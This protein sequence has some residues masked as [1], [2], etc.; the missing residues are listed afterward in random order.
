VLPAWALGGFTR[1][2]AGNPIIAPKPESMFYCP[3]N[4]KNISWESNDTFNPA[5]VIKGKKIVVMYRAEDKSGEGIGFRTS[6]IGYARSVDGIQM[7]RK[8]KPVM[9]P[10]NDDQKE[11]DWP[12]GCE[13]PRVAVTENGMYVMFYTAWN[14]KVARLSVATSKNLKKWTKHGPAFEEAHG[15]KFKDMF[16]KSASI[17]TK[18]QGEKLVITKIKDQYWIYWGE[19]HVYA[20]T[21]SNLTDW[22]P[23]LDN[24]GELKILMSPRKGFFDSSLTEC[25][26]PA[27]VTSA[28][29]VMLYNGKNAGD[30]NRDSTFTA[31]SYCAG[32]ALFDANEPTKFINR[33]DKPFLRPL[34]PYEKS[35]QYVNGTVFIEGLVYF[36]QKWFLYYGCAD[37]RVSV[38]I[39]DP[40]LKTNGDSLP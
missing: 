32:Q 10:G 15:G 11:T 16:T 25:G 35:G 9:Y 37:S 34:L 26:P 29:I 22:M 3:M 30:Q 38:A 36:K 13:D 6:R 40:K 28:G 12:G 1:I 4:K 14:R 2:T 33:L 17:I 23:L 27:V 7:K 39:Y 24:D 21:S 19:Q 5:A 20:A 18:L 31:N 8:T